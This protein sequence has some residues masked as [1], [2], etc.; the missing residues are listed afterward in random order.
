MEDSANATFENELQQQIIDIILE[1]CE[2][3]EEVPEAL[4][5]YYKD[6]IYA[7]FEA[8]ATNY[9]L[10]VDTYIEQSGMT[11]EEFE[12]NLTAGATESAREALVCKI[13]AE[14][15]GISVTDEE[16]EQGIQENYM[17]FGYATPEEYKEAENVEDY[18]DYLLTA[19]V[20]DFIIENANVTV[21]TPAEVVEETTEV[22]E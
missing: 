1:E 9:G 13:I 11:K 10:D 2:F 5:N 7:N 4:Y 3:T 20:L 15:E 8:Y 19:K 6:Q 12:E 21:A 16:L 22:T 17:K 18:R 14:K